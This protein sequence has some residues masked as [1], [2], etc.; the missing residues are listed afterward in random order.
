M[1]GQAVAV[2]VGAEMYV[3]VTPASPPGK[4]EVRLEVALEPCQ[5]VRVDARPLEEG[6]VLA[7]EAGQE[8]TSSAFP[9]NSA[10]RARMS[11]GMGEGRP[12]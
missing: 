11:S 4:V 8:T 9:S 10:M 1:G 6:R 7:P 2:A 5:V 12:P 3:R